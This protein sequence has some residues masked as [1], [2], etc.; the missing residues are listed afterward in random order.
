MLGS[1]PARATVCSPA[2]VGSTPQACADQP[3]VGATTTATPTT[4]AAVVTSSSSTTTL[5]AALDKL[6]LT[7]QAL[8]NASGRRRGGLMLGTAAIPSIF[9]FVKPRP[10]FFFF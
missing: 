9:P 5:Q 3:P 1:T 4:A 2:A 8:L 6:A 10:V 7:Q